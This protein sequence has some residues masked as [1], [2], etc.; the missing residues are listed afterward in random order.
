MSYALDLAPWSIKDQPRFSHRGLLMDTSR[1]F[2]P[3]RTLK[4]IIQSMTYTKMNVLHWH[5]SDS[6]SFP[7]QSTTYPDLWNGSYS[8]YE[9]F[10]QA[11]AADLVE[12][13][14]KR[15][16]RIVPEFDVPG[17]AAS[18]C[19]GYP[20]VC[21][22]PLCPQPLNPATP[23]AFDLMTSFFG[24]LTGNGDETSALFSDD[25][26]HL[27][28]DEVNTDCWTTTPA[29]NNWLNAN[30][31]SAQDAYG[32]FVQKA[33]DIIISQNRNPVNWEEVFL[34]FGN[35]LDPQTIIHIWLDHATLAEVVAAGYRGI[36]SNNDVWYL[37]HLSTTWW[38]FYLNDPYQNITDPSQQ[39][40]VLGGEVCMWGETV[41]TSD[42]E[43]TIWPRA[44][45]AAERLWSAADVTD[46]TQALSRLMWFR[47]LLN[48]R[49]VA[50][51]P[52][53]NDQARSSPAGPGP[54]GIQ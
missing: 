16:V 22:S 11:D 47:C 39:A 34:N 13:A 30:N 10:T 42:A 52:V 31:Y 53:N 24:E 18:W 37:D 9:R 2:E 25:M 36:L 38:Q 20:D 40:L 27:G 48:S 6:Q 50:A 5:L 21:P 14:R 43:Q 17:H 7:L 33:H 3:I 26:F 23:A 51:A 46:V 44:A 45:A 4:R 12:F 19:I 15:G 1:H 32:Y 8:P 29:I 35:K 49:G 54:C 28:G 41:D